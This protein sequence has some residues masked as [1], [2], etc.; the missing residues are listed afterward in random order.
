MELRVT[1]FD[2]FGPNKDIKVILVELLDKDLEEELVQFYRAYGKPDH[3]F[4]PDRPNWHISKR[5]VEYDV[6]VG[7]II[8]AHQ[9]DIKILGPHDPC[10]ILKLSKGN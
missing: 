4:Y 1:G 8:I 6:V 9:V 7:T 2:Q 5:N 3:G 10:D